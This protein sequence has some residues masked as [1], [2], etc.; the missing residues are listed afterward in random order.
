MKLLL[1]AL[2]LLVTFSIP[3]FAADEATQA[4][5][6]IGKINGIALACQQPALSSR[7]RNAVQ[8]GAPKTR[9]YGEAFENATNAAFLAQGKGVCP[10]ANELSAQLGAAESA[11]SKA[12][13][14]R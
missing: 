14:A 4:V 5:E 2:T 9:A 6:A 8:T 13:P 7:A 3:S 10:S 11:L 1:S 12:F